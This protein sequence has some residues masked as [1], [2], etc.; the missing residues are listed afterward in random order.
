MTINDSSILLNSMVACSKSAGRGNVKARK[1][2][3]M[4][5]LPDTA[6]GHTPDLE[7]LIGGNEHKAFTNER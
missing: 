4:N 6:E 1:G 2:V 7:L 5:V 3:L